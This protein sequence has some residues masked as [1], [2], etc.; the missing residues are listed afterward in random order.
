MMGRKTW[1]WRPRGQLPSLPIANISGGQSNRTQTERSGRIVR[2]FLLSCRSCCLGGTVTPGLLP[3]PPPPHTHSC[4]QP[5][6]GGRGENGP[7]AMALPTPP[8]H[9]PGSFPGHQHREARC[10]ADAAVRCVCVGGGSSG[11]GGA[12]KCLTLTEGRIPFC[13]PS[14]GKET[15]AQTAPQP[16]CTELREATRAKQSRHLDMADFCR[17]QAGRQGG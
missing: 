12:G 14:Q 5:T 9:H 16:L 13:S 8:H 2:R 17:W 4:T 11:P 7:L 10:G 15:P 6:L 3:S 1:G